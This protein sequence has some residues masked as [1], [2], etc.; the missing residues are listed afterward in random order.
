MELGKMRISEAYPHLKTV[1]LAYGLRLNRAK[2]FK[3][4]KVV[5]A[6]LYCRELC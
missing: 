6:N 1:A 3:F 2:E 4:A 5:L